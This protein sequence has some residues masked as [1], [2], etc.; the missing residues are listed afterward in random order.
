MVALKA[1]KKGESDWKFGAR[2]AIVVS[3][4]WQILLGRC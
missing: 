1:V 3:I 4:V 2:V